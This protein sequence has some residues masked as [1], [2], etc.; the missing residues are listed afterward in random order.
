MDCFLGTRKQK[1]ELV[2]GPRKEALKIGSTDSDKPLFKTPMTPPPVSAKGGAAPKEKEVSGGIS[3]SPAL[4]ANQEMK[5]WEYPDVTM[6]SDGPGEK[7]DR[8]DVR[9]ML[10]SSKNAR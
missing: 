9:K 2:I 8:G 3:I 10:I 4:K 1:S 5:M 7:A 6:L